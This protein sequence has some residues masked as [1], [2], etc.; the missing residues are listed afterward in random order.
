LRIIAARRSSSVRVPSKKVSIEKS[1]VDEKN[2]M[3]TVG[4]GCRPDYGGRF[5][6]AV[7]AFWCMEFLV[8][9]NE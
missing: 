3:R 5:S 2:Q 4:I 1:G 7:L 9:M 8:S 6:E